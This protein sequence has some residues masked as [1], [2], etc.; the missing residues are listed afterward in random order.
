MYTLYMVV[1]IY[2]ELF[3]VLIFPMVLNATPE[4]G[5]AAGIEE[6]TG[7]LQNK[8]KR[9]M[10]IGF[11]VSINVAPATGRHSNDDVV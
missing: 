2:V 5:T 1:M 10:I 9:P 7:F 8:D 3:Y 6:L 11:L 4:L